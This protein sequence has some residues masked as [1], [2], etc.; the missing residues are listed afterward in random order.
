MKAVRILAGADLPHFEA[1]V[2]LR[3]VVRRHELQANNAAD[4]VQRLFDLYPA[5]QAVSARTLRDAPPRDALR[6]L[7]RRARA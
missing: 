1:W 6:L 7:D 5:A 2:T 3:G 4:A